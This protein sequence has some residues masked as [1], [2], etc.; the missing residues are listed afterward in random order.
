MARLTKLNYLIINYSVNNHFQYQG[1]CIDIYKYLAACTN[2]SAYTQFR[3]NLKIIYNSI[4]KNRS[5]KIIA[6]EVKSKLLYW[7]VYRIKSIEIKLKYYV[8]K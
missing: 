5:E 3:N 6:I 7:F 2:K 1:S 8:Q 4:N